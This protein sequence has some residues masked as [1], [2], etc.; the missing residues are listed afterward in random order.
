MSFCWRNRT[1]ITRFELLY[2]RPP[3]T[4]ISMATDD[5]GSQHKCR[6]TKVLVLGH[7]CVRRLHDHLDRSGYAS[8]G[9]RPAGQVVKLVGMSGLRFPRLL[10]NLREVCEPG[11][12]LVLLDFGTYDFAAGCSEELLA[13]RVI[14]VA[15]TL[16][17]SYGVKRVV[18]MEVFPRTHGQYRC[19]PTFKLEAR[20]YNI[21][22]RDRL[23]SSPQIH[24]H[25][26]QGLVANWQQYLVDGVHLTE[27]AL[28]CRSDA[29]A[30]PA[31]TTL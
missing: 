1:S 7:S 23:S 2:S 3:D 29:S 10:L 14:A 9:L 21:L 12:D 11:Y 18:L 28:A 8:F 16:L 6:P 26:H 13:D 25:H 4:A 15:E 22:I 17:S 27:R 20:Q 30:T 19:P 5:V 31:P 24:F